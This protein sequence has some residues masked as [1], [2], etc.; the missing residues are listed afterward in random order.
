MSVCARARR[1]RLSWALMVWAARYVKFWR[2]LFVFCVTD[3]TVVVMVCWRRV[4][5]VF[6]QPFV[7]PKHSLCVSLTHGR[8]W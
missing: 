6:S 5:T 7:L 4:R 2:S 1:L 3:E 8:Q